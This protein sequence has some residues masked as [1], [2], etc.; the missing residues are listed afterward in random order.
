M[1]KLLSCCKQVPHIYKH[2]PH[3]NSLF[4]KNENEKDKY[5]SGEIVPNTSVCV[6]SCCAGKRPDYFLKLVELVRNKKLSF[7]SVFTKD[8][9]DCGNPKCPGHTCT[10]Q[11]PYHT[12]EDNGILKN[13]F[14]DEHARKL[15]QDRSDLNWLSEASIGDYKDWG[16]VHNR[17]PYCGYKRQIWYLEWKKNINKWRKSGQLGIFIRQDRYSELGYGQQ[18]EFDYLNK[19]KKKHNFIDLTIDEFNRLC[20]N[21]S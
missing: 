10:K 8:G 21:H 13:I 15:L 11:C 6:L 12:W 1:I 17:C 2:R 19:R 16:T 3:L 7:C 4:H 18:D 5:F 20:V 9:G 14:D